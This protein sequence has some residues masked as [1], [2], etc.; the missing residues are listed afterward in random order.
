[1]ARIKENLTAQERIEIIKG[2]KK[3]LGPGGKNWIKG[4]WF[5]KKTK[6]FEPGS[7]H[8]LPKG[9]GGVG[10]DYQREA[11]EQVAPSEADCWCLLGALEESAYRLKLSERRAKAKT[12]GVKTSIKNRMIAYTKLWKKQR[13]LNFI[14]VDEFNDW[15][16]TEWKDIYKVMN[17]RIKELEKEV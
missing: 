15:R 11:W 9:D 6:Y 16:D 1:M 7:S 12:L 10:Y 14:S 17:D 8:Y 13:M 4:Q 3:L 2:A 5:A